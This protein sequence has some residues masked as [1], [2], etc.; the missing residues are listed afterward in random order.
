MVTLLHAMFV[1]LFKCV[2]LSVVLVIGINLG[3]FLRIK[4]DAKKNQKEA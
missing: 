3:K 2:L 4:K 1:A